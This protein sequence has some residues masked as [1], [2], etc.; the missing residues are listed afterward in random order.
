MGRA[1]G[2]EVRDSSIRILSNKAIAA[3]VGANRPNAAA[4]AFN[5]TPEPVL[6]I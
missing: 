1:S 6:T 3:G 4:E 2:V 5:H